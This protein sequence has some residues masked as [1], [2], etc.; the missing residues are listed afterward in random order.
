MKTDN[1]VE[2]LEFCD[3]MRNVNYGTR[4]NRV[5]EK[6]SKPILQFTKNGELVK[7]YPSA[8]EAERQTKIHQGHISQCCKGK[9]KSCG[10]YLWKYKEDAA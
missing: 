9:L 6:L 1:R 5:A 8:K 2:N 7:E 3:A 4:N 10:G